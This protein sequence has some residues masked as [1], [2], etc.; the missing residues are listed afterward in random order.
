MKP[1]YHKDEFLDRQ[2]KAP[3]MQSFTFITVVGGAQLFDCQYLQF[4]F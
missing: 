1:F 2:K 4:L 3:R